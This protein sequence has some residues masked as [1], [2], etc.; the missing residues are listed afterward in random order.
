M[1]S[2]V[3]PNLMWQKSQYA[4]LVH[5]VPSAIYFTRSPIGG[6]LIRRSVKTKVL[7]VAK[8]KLADAER[9]VKLPDLTA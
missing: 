1:A 5:Y 4:D 2:S 6:K 8:L 7:S 9:R 3:L